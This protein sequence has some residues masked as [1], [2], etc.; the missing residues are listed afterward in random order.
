MFRMGG[1]HFT[2][3]YR[4]GKLFDETQEAAVAEIEKIFKSFLGSFEIVPFSD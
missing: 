3:S 4:Y 2:L 1:A